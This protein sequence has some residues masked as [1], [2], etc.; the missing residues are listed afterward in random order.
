VDDIERKVQRDVADLLQLDEV[1]LDDDF[2]S[3][4]GASLTALE[5]ASRLRDAYGVEVSLAAIFEA[6]S[7]REIAAAVRAAPTS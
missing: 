5:L 6:T 2:L 7:I 4:G 3:L 1:R